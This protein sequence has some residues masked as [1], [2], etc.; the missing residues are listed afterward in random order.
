MLLRKRPD[1]TAKMLTANQANA[2]FSAGPR[3]EEGKH[4]VRLSRPPHGQRVRSFCDAIA[5]VGGESADFDRITTQDYCET[6][7]STEASKIEP[8]AT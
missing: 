4:R 8:M 5:T 6:S 1:V 2:S 7:T 3:S